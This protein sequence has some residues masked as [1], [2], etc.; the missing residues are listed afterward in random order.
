[1]LRSALVVAFFGAVLFVGCGDE[2]NPD[3]VPGPGMPPLATG[4]PIYYGS[5]D[6]N[7]AHAAVVALTTNNGYFCSGTLITPDVVLTAAHC[8]EG[9]SPG[10]AS[11]FFGQNAYNTGTYRDVDTWQIYPQYDNFNLIGDIGIIH[12]AAAAPAGVTPIPYLPAELKL[13]SADVGA[14]VDFSGFG[15]TETGSDGAKLHVTGVI[16]VVCAGPSSCSNG[17][18]SP[19]TFA[20][21]QGNGGPCFGDSGGPA[22][23][24]RGA[25]EYVAGVTSYGDE[26]CTDF[27]VST[28]ASEY[29]S[30][31]AAFIAGGGAS[32]I[33]G[34]GL[35]DNA[36]GLADCADTACAGDAACAGPSACEGPVVIGCGTALNDTTAGGATV[37]NT[38]GCQQSPGSRWNGPEVAF[39]LSIPAGAEVTARMQPTSGDLDLFLLPRQSASCDTASCLEASMGE[40]VAAESLTF[41]A[42]TATAY[43]LVDTWDTASPFS[44]S[45][46]CAGAVEVCGN[47]IDDD[48][49]SLA[50]CA[51][52][53]CVGLATC[54]TPV[55]QCDNSTDDDGD[56]LTD[57][58]DADCNGSASCPTDPTG[59]GTG[60]TRRGRSASDGGCNGTGAGQGG[61]A[62]LALA[63]LLVRRRRGVASR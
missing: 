34:N 38:S 47:G 15:L 43:L 40:G 49:D 29:A 13:T 55:E 27:G 10:S 52:S 35:D 30:W 2:E 28:N 58:G 54:Q 14:T 36:D 26:S 60:T 53:D 16:D 51:D 21:S 50:D 62:T 12:L 41:T 25:T 48:G 5:P 17:N 61:A 4:R 8:L 39:E 19:K 18:V 59:G 42:S 33:C 1:M 32:E 7:P 31:I 44:L 57:C 22:F 24:L 45:I 11:I 23:I 9:S 37:F 63:V 6:T 46:T 56:G 20:Y 3:P